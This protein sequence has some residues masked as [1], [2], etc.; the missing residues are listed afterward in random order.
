MPAL[1]EHLSPEAGTEHVFSSASARHGGVVKRAIRD[2]ERLAGYEYFMSEGE[3][4][5]FQAVRN[6][7]HFVIFCNQ[8]PIRRV[9]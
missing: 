9:R 2:V 8:L 4:R 7:K 3:R 6:G 5:G 1:P